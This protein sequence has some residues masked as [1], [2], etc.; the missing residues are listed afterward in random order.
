MTSGGLKGLK[1]ILE[2]EIG[3]DDSAQ[4]LM[5]RERGRSSVFTS[6]QDFDRSSLGGESFEELELDFDQVRKGKRIL[7][8]YKCIIDEWYA[9][10]IV[11][12]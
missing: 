1:I 4:M 10:W 6:D 12:N 9:Y 11:D 5:E 7:W 8:W 3:Q 2:L